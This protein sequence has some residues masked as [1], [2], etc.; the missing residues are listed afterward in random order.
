MVCEYA[1]EL[2]SKAN[3]V[4]RE[5]TSAN[6]KKMWLRSFCLYLSEGISETRGF[7]LLSVFFRTRWKQVL[8]WD[9]LF[10]CFIVATKHQRLFVILILV[11]MQSIQ[12]MHQDI[13]TIAKDFQIFYRST[14]SVLEGHKSSSQLSRYDFFKISC[15]LVRYS[16]CTWRSFQFCNWLR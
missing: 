7:Y 8:V 6:E 11:W 2:M 4:L 9:H 16:F 10:I 15:E 12:S 14:K 5:V 3:G 1:G 13:S